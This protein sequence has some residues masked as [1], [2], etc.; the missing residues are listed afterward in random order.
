M[1]YI[2]ILPGIIIAILIGVYIYLADFTPEDNTEEL[3]RRID[4]LELKIDSLNLRKDS[5]RTV[6]DSTHI[7]I[8]TNEKRYQ[9]R[10]N[11][12]IAQPSSAD[13]QFI[14]DYIRLNSG[15]TISSDSSGT[16]KIE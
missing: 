9:E 12:I 5:I 11:V 16:R 3:L 14:A 6:I 8:I 7:K 4:S 15:K 13:S 10:V 2:Y 1:K